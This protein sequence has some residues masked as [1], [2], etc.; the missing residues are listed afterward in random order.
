MRRRSCPHCA[1][2]LP[3]AGRRCRHCDWVKGARHKPGAAISW[4]RRTAVWALVV[5]ALVVVAGQY[6]YRN[7]AAIA[8]WYTNYATQYLPEES[9]LRPAGDAEPVRAR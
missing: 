8:D 6:A 1:R 5:C 4:W 2:L 3:Y 7:A 9:P